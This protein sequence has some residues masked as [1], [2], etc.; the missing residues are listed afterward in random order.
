MIDD[1][2]YQAAPVIPCELVQDFTHDPG[3]DPPCKIVQDFTEEDLVT[4]KYGGSFK[5]VMKGIW[6]RFLKPVGKTLLGAIPRLFQGVLPALSSGN[7]LA[8]VPALL[9]AAKDMGKEFLIN[10]GKAVVSANP[11]VQKFTQMP[12]AKG[13]MDQL[14]QLSP[15]AGDVVKQIAGNGRAREVEVKSIRIAVPKHHKKKRGQ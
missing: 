8:A 4:E 13:A 6:N 15:K 2:T 12:L 14:S 7:P 9:N 3:F 10:S 5:S 11:E 1:F